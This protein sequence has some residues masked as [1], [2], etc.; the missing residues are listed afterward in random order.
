M[1]RYLLLNKVI[2]FKSLDDDVEAAKIYEGKYFPSHSTDYHNFKT[3]KL[4][5]AV[6]LYWILIYQNLHK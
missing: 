6:V 2:M 4:F 3:N 5:D 1:H